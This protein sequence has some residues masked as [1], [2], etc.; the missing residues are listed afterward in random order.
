MYSAFILLLI[1]ATPDFINAEHRRIRAEGLEA[2]DP[3]ERVAI[4]G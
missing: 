2:E 1:R 3:E 4:G